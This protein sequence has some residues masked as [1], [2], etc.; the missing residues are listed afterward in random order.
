PV[1]D[2]IHNLKANNEEEEELLKVLKH[3]FYLVE[4]SLDDATKVIDDLKTSEPIWTKYRTECEDA[5][6]L[7]LTIELVWWR[8]PTGENWLDLMTS[9]SDKV[10]GLVKANLNNLYNRLAL[11]TKAIYPETELH[12]DRSPLCRL[13]PIAQDLYRAWDSFLDCDSDALDKI[14]K[15]LVGTISF[16]SSY[17][18]P[19]FYLHHFTR[20]MRQHV[21][22]QLTGLTRRRLQTSNRREAL[23]DEIRNLTF[24]RKLQHLWRDESPS[25]G[26]SDRFHCFRLAMLNQISALRAWDLASW[27]EAIKQQHDSIREL[28]RFE[29]QQYDVEFSSVAIQLSVLS[30]S[31]K[32][33]DAFLIDAV[34]KADKAPE[35]NREILIRSL[36]SM[37]RLMWPSVLDALFLISDAIP[38]KL[39]TPVAEWCVGYVN[40]PIKPFGSKTSDAFLLWTNIIRYTPH[41]EDLCAILHPIAVDVANNPLSWSSVS[42]GLQVYLINAPFELAIQVGEEMFKLESVDENF[43]PHRWEIIYRASLERPELGEKF[44]DQLSA[45][46]KNPVYEF[47]L[48]FL[49][50]SDKTFRLTNHERFRNWCREKILTL[51][52]EISGRK[53]EKR[54]FPLGFN[55]KVLGL[56]DWPNDE[57]ELI[58]AV[59]ATIKAPFIQMHEISTLIVC[60]AD[61]VLEGSKAHAELIRQDFFNW[62]D[63]LPSGIP[64][65]DEELSG[66]LSSIQISFP[67]QKDIFVN[68][69]YLVVAMAESDRSQV[70]GKITDWLVANIFDSPMRANARMLYLVCLL[71]VAENF[72]SKTDVVS[73]IQLL[74]M[75]AVQIAQRARG[76]YKSLEILLKQIA[77]LLKP[78]SEDP[79]SLS[80]A[81]DE[82]RKS[83]LF[84]ALLSWVPEFV[85]H[86]SSDVR[87]G[88]SQI[89]SHWES[90]EELPSDF[91]ELFKK[92]QSDSRARVRYSASFAE[93]KTAGSGLHS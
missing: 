92:L 12:W 76:D 56:V 53:S 6:L 4:Q 82:E 8:N 38:E 45:T 13:E 42:E 71:G 63:E 88:I 75:K 93:R 67:G 27:F 29:N 22:T 15:R 83:L 73:Y 62:L 37:R 3:A 18:L 61:L 80:K 26:A 86:N 21:G 60:L 51:S 31:F 58:N 65:G 34:Q 5:A 74:I 33:Q 9:W 44:K 47:R 57:K 7:T 11:Q 14:L 89:L 79:A 69:C 43:N 36:I 17:S 77:V 10:D 25:K 16:E 70:G 40:N 64:M 2:V 81:T 90:H 87:A 66:P 55:L 32:R 35:E 19:V 28:L 48:L 85:N 52:R 24:Y 23:F 49:P 68:F 78:D 39:L 30:A 46:A 50:F 1:R 84:S 91:P 20:F 59:L 41:S 72:L 54:E